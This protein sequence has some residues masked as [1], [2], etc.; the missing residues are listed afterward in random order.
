MQML[1]FFTDN[2][3]FTFRA[4]DHLCGFARPS[5][6][7]GWAVFF[8]HPL[9]TTRGKSGS[10]L[11]GFG[12]SLYWLSTWMELMRSSH[13]G[14]EVALCLLCSCVLYLRCVSYVIYPRW[15]WYCP[16]VLCGIRLS[17]GFQSQYHVLT[18]EVSSFFRTPFLL[19][20]VLT[21]YCLV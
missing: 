16:W 3:A 20:A 8:T 17:S 6:L 14:K 21:S 4:E 1:L 2:T 12:Y 10:H 9:E 13:S 11:E 19:A 5:P 18:M 15:V 7:A